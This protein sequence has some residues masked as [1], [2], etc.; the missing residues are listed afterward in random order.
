M[1]LACPFRDFQPAR[2][3]F[4]G[5]AQ[6]QERKNSSFCLG[7]NLTVSNSPLAGGAIGYSHLEHQQAKEVD[8]RELGRRIYPGRCTKF[9]GKGVVGNALRLRV[10][11]F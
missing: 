6:G 10:T 1:A 8:E 4:I 11:R 3:V 2:Y 5:H 9:G 7:V